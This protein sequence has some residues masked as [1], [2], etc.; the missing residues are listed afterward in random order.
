MGLQAIDATLSS[1]AEDL[2][3]RL[4]QDQ[5]FDAPDVR[6]RTCHRQLAGVS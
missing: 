1:D 5:T 4:A 3:P 2:L 6:K